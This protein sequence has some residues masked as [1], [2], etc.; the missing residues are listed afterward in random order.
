MR[1]L[2]AGGGEPTWIAAAGSHL[3]YSSLGCR[4]DHTIRDQRFCKKR[5]SV[6]FG[7]SQT[8]GYYFFRPSIVAAHRVVLPDHREAPGEREWISQI[9]GKLESFLSFILSLIGIAQNPKRHRVE[10]MTTHAGILSK[11]KRERSMLLPIVQT[12]AAF[13]TRMRFGK[14]TFEKPAAARGPVSLNEHSVILHAWRQTSHFLGI[15]ECHSVLAA[16]QVIAP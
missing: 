9:A 14:L 15:T 8:F 11:L 1:Q 2:V 16:N 3:I 13:E 7:K 10:T 12:A 4:A 6:L 5:K